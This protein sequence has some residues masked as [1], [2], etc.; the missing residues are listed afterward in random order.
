[1]KILPEHVAHDTERKQRFEREAQTIASLDHPN[2]CVLYDVGHEAGIDFLVMEY[3]EGQ[4]LADRLQKGALP[5]DDALEYAS[6]I[7]SALEKAHRK[8]VI[9]RDIKPANIMITAAGIKVLDFGL[10]K[11]RATDTSGSEFHS[12]IPTQQSVTVS[13]SILGTI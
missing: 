10:A 9:H 2:I 3:L 8:G 1:V 11:L 5:L 4:T 7:A 12:A 13:G 6:Q